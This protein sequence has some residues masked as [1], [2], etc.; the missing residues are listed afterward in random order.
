MPATQGGR[1]VPNFYILSEEG[2][3]ALKDLRSTLTTMIHITHTAKRDMQRSP[4]VI[5]G[6][7]ELHALF[8]TIN[9]QVDTVLERLGNENWIGSHRKTPQ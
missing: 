7:N 4:L 3:E 1:H 8:A 6:L 5:V 9:E 2:Y